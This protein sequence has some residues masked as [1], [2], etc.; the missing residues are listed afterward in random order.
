MKSDVWLN[1]GY[2]KGYEI[3]ITPIINYNIW[4]N[5][6]NEPIGVTINFEYANDVHYELDY[7]DWLLFLQE[8]LHIQAS[9]ELDEAL[10]SLFSKMEYGSLEKE[11][12]K[13]GIEFSKIA[14]Y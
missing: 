8:S 4:T 12:A 1:K 3:E 11:L 10:R 6:K 13:N 9:S 7:V 5:K 2:K 14:F